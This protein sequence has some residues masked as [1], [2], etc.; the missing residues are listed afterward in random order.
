VLFTRG[1]AR[2][3]PVTGSAGTGRWPAAGTTGRA[4][5]CGRG[6]AWPQKRSASLRR[7]RGAAGK[8]C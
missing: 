8:R 5:G 2:V 4:A 6:R 1:R 3:A 7:A